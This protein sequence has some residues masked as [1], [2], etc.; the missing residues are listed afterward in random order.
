MMMMSFV[1][2]CIYTV[3]PFLISALLR[4]AYNSMR[5]FYFLLHAA[6]YSGEGRKRKGQGDLVRWVLGEGVGWSGMGGRWEAL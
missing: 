5:C 6:V 3:F 4:L 2:C 1:C